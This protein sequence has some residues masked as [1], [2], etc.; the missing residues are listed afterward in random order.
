[1][2]VLTTILPVAFTSE[3][4]LEGYYENNFKIAQ[5]TKKSGRND[6]FMPFTKNRIFFVF[7]FAVKFEKFFVRNEL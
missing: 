4:R 1:V 2:L 5:E 3:Y 6:V 7:N